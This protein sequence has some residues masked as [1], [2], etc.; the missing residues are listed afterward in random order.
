MSVPLKQT[1]NTYGDWHGDPC[2]NRRGGTP[3]QLPTA[4]DTGSF[5]SLVRHGHSLGCFLVP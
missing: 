2:L 1:T 4:V 3:D 5:G